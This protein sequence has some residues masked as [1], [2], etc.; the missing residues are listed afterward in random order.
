[1]HFPAVAVDYRNALPGV[2]DKE[3]LPSPVGLAHNQIKFL[4]PGSRG[5][6]KPAI[7]QA[8][9]RGRLI[10]LPQQK[11]RDAL[12]FE[13]AVDCGPIRYQVRRWDSGRDDRKQ[14][15]FQRA[16]IIGVGQGPRYTR[17]LCPTDVL[18]D[19]RPTDAE[20]VSDFPITEPLPPFKPQHF[21]DV[22]HG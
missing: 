21:M 12:A 11:Q 19:R 15:P 9:G 18:C 4:R 20:A 13:F 6:T 14:Q 7:L 2:I 5:V 17:R 8:V 10:F 22:T 3:L 16:L 1:M